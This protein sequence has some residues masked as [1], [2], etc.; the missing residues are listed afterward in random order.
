MVRLR[1]TPA[2]GHGSRAR[3]ASD[4][5]CR[6]VALAGQWAF[7][8]A[9]KSAASPHRGLDFAVG[10]AMPFLTRYGIDDA[11]RRRRQEFLGLTETDAANVR[12]LREA[13]ARH[14]QEFAERFYDHLMTDPH[15]RAFVRDPET[16]KR[17]KGLQA[18]YFGQLLQGVY[19]EAYFEGR[20]RVG[21]AHH[22]I[23]LEPVWYLGAYNQ[24]VQL[25]FPLFFQAFGG[26]VDQVL[27]LLLSLVK[28]IFLDVGLALDTYFQEA[29]AQLRRRNEEL[30]QALGLYWQSQRREQQLHKMASHEIRG[31]LA[32]VITGLETLQDAPGTDPETSAAAQV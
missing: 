22:R 27:P 10:A 5:A 14:A 4:D 16:L 31:G 8:P 19:D 28:V 3:A 29:T 32:A 1:E 24:Y 2:T 18:D 23:G 15:T 25:T 17:L 21:A 7:S 11:E 9:R 26:D 6:D 20:L 30:Q 13:F 12:R